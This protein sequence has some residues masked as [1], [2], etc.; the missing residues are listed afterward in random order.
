MAL[1]PADLLIFKVREEDTD[2]TIQKKKKP[3]Q[4]NAAPMNSKPTQPTVISRPQQSQQPQKQTVFQSPKPDVQYMK[5]KP[6]Q[7]SQPQAPQPAPKPVEPQPAWQPPQPKPAEPKKSLWGTLTS[8]KAPD[9]P[10]DIEDVVEDALKVA[11]PEQK[12]EEPVKAAAPVDD[13]R[14]LIE[15]AIDERLEEEGIVDVQPKIRVARKA[16]SARDSRKLA[17]NMDCSTHPW[18]RAY[19]L[20]EYCGRPFC[21][22]DIMEYGNAYYCLDDIDKVSFAIRNTEMVKYSRLSLIS[23]LLLIAAPLLYGYYGIA[24]ML[25][26][27]A[28]IKSAGIMNFILAEN[29]P[30]LI[31][32]ADVIL[33]AFSFIAAISIILESQMSFKLTT[34]IG[35][36]TVAIF[37]YQFLGNVSKTYIALI[38]A[39]SFVSLV[40]LAYSRVAFDS[41]PDDGFAARE[42]ELSKS[43][44]F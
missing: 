7:Q 43:T 17:K 40:T 33:M 13:G 42:V 1:D 34:L 41:V 44:G 16:K 29:I 22:E 12:K 32:V 26:V 39:C 21:Y 11:A 23:A 3:D 36:I 20:C 15:A 9:K 24:G 5:P 19:A 31:I 38:A 37:S 35:L 30:E 25:T 14:D 27:F 8:Y 10:I 18:R 2:S 4:Q 28:A 6:V